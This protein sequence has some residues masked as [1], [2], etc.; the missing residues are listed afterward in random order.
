MKNI[1]LENASPLHYVT[2]SP[3]HLLPLH[4]PP[5]LVL[6]PLKA[7]MFKE[8][9]AEGDSALPLLEKASSVADADA[10]AVATFT[11]WSGNL[12]KVIL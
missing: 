11:G 7:L 5:K 9:F 1:P 3:L 2:T 12:I 8:S 4:L 10:D 6:L